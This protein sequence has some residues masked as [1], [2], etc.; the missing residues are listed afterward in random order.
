MRSIRLDVYIA[1]MEQLFGIFVIRRYWTGVIHA[2]SVY[3]TKLAI[4][5][6]DRS[7]NAKKSVADGPNKLC[8]DEDS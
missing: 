7:G 1:D 2:I 4:P 8:R 5:I 6:F 3:L